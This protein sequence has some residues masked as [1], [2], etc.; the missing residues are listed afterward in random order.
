MIEYLA[1]VQ[2]LTFTSLHVVIVLI[3][4]CERFQVL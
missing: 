4:P 2:V 1:L 3:S